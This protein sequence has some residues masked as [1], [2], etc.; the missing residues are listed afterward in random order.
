MIHKRGV[1]AVTTLGIGSALLL[2]GGRAFRERALRARW[3]ELQTGMDAGRFEPSMVEGLPAPAQRYLLHAIAPGAPLAFSLTTSMKGTIQ[4]QPGAAPLPMEAQAVIAP[5]RGFIWR[6]RAGRGLMR[7]SGHDSYFQGKGEMHWSLYGF[8]PVAK[9]GG[10]D[11]TRS[12]AGRLAAEATMVPAALLPQHGAEWEAE[13]DT[14]ARVRLTVGEE[15]ATVTVAIDGDGRLQRVSLMRWADDVGQGAPG[16]SRF[17]VC[18]FTDERTFGGYTIPT[19]FR[20]G[21]RVGDPDEFPFFVAAI[22]QAA[23]H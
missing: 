20:A 21:W 5:P 9:A 18:D 10:P 3:H 14:T 15:T 17:D 1:A 11:V 16:Y 4:L 6:A 23:Y 19:R 12:A 13:D 2:L 8:V 22:D 7:V